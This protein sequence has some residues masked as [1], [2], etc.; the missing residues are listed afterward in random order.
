MHI[1]LRVFLDLYAS[2]LDSTY[3]L[4]VTVTLRP[5][6]RRQDNL[7]THSMLCCVNQRLLDS[8][9]VHLFRLDQKRMMG[10]A[11]QGVKVVARIDGTDDKVG[12]VELRRCMVPV[13]STVAQIL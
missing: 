2:L 12:I 6:R 1:E 8:V 7:N 13:V 11:N 9:V 5:V 10:A 4:A 3:S